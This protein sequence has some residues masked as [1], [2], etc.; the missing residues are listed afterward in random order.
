[1]SAN[2]VKA[3][4][5]SA[6][7]HLL[8]IMVLWYTQQ[9]VPAPVAQPKAIQAFV[10][11]PI[12][13]PA[14]PP[15]ENSPQVLPEATPKTEPEPD[16]QS[17][18]ESPKQTAPASKLKTPPE[19]SAE[20]PS[21]APQTTANTTAPADNISQTTD[22]THTTTPIQQTGVTMSLAERSL[23]IANRRHADVSSAA[24]AASQQR[25]DLR[26]R[27]ATTAKA[28]LK[29]EH[30][31]DNVLMVLK[32]GSFIEKIGDYCY[33]A[34]QGANLRADI[35]S[36]KPVPCGKDKNAAMYDRIMSKVGQDR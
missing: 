4:G 19:V 3:L 33:H 23:A 24:L 22:A 7:L 17:I 25:P 36:M 5:W 12:P 21:A 31:A 14:K 9:S 30:A 1:M 34:N 18:V 2:S 28:Q 10:Y 8:V 27:P 29:P 15:I 13:R 35:S 32:D 20:A 6:L 16:P 11:Q 26:D